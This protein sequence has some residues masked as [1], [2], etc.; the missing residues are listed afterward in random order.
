[1]N[2][3]RRAFALLS[4]EVLR[5]VKRSTLLLMTLLLLALAP[6]CLAAESEA[7]PSLMPNPTDPQTWMSALWVIIIFTV[8]V[9]ILYPTAW[10]QVL[11]GLKS[12]EQ[13][14]RNDIAEAEATRAKAEATLNQYNVQLAAAEER[15]RQ[16]LNQAVAD[17]E[18]LATSIRMKAQ[19]EAE[20]IKERAQK[21]IEAARDSALREIYEKTAE[22]ATN[23]AEKIIRRNLNAA[24]QQDLVRESLQQLQTV[25]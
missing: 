20:E 16:M 15:I 23:V 5:M 4:Y 12:R 9:I 3:A 18:K 2:S 19:T 22:L 13:R 10:K 24:D 6:L 25:K 14:I 7:Q 1:M 21:D 17:G 8:M 11:A